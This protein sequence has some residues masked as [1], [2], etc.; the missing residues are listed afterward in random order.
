MKDI[1]IF[2][3]LLGWFNGILYNVLRE[4]TTVFNIKHYFMYNNGIMIVINLC[5]F[6]LFL[7]IELIN[8]I[9]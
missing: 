7:M 2:C 9:T 4:N 5:N 6:L 1:A 3:F 8:T